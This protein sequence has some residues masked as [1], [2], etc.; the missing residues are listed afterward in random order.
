[1]LIPMSEL[2]R[3]YG[4][5]PKVVAHVGAHNGEEFDQYSRLNVD[6]VHWFEANPNQFEILSDR[7]ANMDTQFLVQRAIWDTDNETLKFK[8]TSN[9]LSSSLF[10]LGTHSVKYPDILPKEEIDVTTM[11]LDS[12][13]QDKAKPDFINLDIQGSEL[14]ALLGSQKILNE[15][16]FIYTEVSYEELYLDAPLANEIDF[17]LNELGFKKVMSRK[18]PQD[19]WGDVLYINTRSTKMP[20]SR[21]L[22]RIVRNTTY[23][24][25]ST[26]Y[27]IRL[28]I[29][30]WRNS[31]RTS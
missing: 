12:Y 9:S 22:S 24:I 23:S 16:S 4:V 8:V 11:R 31:R 26:V 20:L 1:M 17:Y 29:H 15:V 3:D 21:I 2:S 6:E 19:G 25:R 27:S 28:A 14:K 18:L 30:T 7:F 5:R 13:F 10:E